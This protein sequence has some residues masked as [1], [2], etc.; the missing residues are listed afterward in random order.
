MISLAS[1]HFG[2]SYPL[3]V[4]SSFLNDWQLV[5]FP[6]AIKSLPAS[7]PMA[8]IDNW[9][10]EI[11]RALRM[12]RVTDA[13]RALSAALEEMVRTGDAVTGPTNND[14]SFSFPFHRKDAKF[15]VW[16][17]KQ[18]GITEVD[19]MDAVAAA[20]IL[21]SE[22]P[23]LAHISGRQR[24]PGTEPTLTSRKLTSDE[25]ILTR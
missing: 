13:R 12:H 22:G 10:Y 2:H 9:K 5:V 4:R 24:I 3:C 23:V 21:P 18:R 8:K 14:Y 19:Q 11:R 20:I 1:C 7:T 6:I 25:A 17:I 15:H 16:R